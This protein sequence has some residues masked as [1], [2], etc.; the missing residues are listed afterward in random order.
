MSFVGYGSDENC[1]EWVRDTDRAT[2]SLSQRRT[3]NR[4]ERL[5]KSHP[6]ECE[7]IARNSD[8]SICAHVPVSWI[9]ISSLRK[10]TEGQRERARESMKLFHM[11][12]GNSPCENE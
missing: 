10:V 5:A 11:N 8:G 2:L 7:V 1:I 4:I 9:K 12:R 3:I 6:A